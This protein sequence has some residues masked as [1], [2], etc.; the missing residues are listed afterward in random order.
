MLCYLPPFKHAGIGSDEMKRFRGILLVLSAALAAPAVAQVS[1][2]SDT[3]GFVKA[4][5]DR[6]GD[7]ALQLLEARGESLLNSRN[8]K[9]Q[10]ALVVAVA[11]RDP[12]WTPFLLSQGADP[13]YAAKD[14]ET[15]LI[16]A[17]RI[18]YLDGVEWLLQKGAKVDGTNRM[19]ETPL[20][21]AVQHRQT[22]VV[23]ILLAK[24]ADPDKADSAAGYSAR[25]YAKRDTRAREILALIEAGK[26]AKPKAAP[27]DLNSFKL[28]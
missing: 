9:G 21:V 13:N 10:T 5:I 14:G 26:T 1:Y 6:D 4:V 7:T 19:G 25:D 24:G 27:E 20:I 18:G 15:P 8:A 2:V 16:A 3:E 12:V 28:E 11:R 22:Q 23:K 17:A